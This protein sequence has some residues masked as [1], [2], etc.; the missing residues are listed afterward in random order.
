LES[1]TLYEQ[2]F[3]FPTTGKN[4]YRSLEGHRMVRTVWLRVSAVL[5]FLLFIAPA[6]FAASRPAKSHPRESGAFARIA[7]A[8]GHLLPPG[9]KSG[10]TMDPDGKPQLA[11]PPAVATSD[12]GGTMDP[13]GRK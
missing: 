8:L 11:S 2:R 9:L 12:S 7:Q 5:V 6:G 1:A 10:G 3:L 4:R 13:D